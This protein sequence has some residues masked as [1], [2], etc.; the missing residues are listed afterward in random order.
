VRFNKA[1][2]PELD[3][4]IENLQKVKANVLGVVMTAFDHKKSS[5]YYYT[6]Y[7]YKYAYD[8]YY[9]YHEKTT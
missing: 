8:S 4:T 9:S 2:E 6:S 7:Y 1:K 3:L 5:G